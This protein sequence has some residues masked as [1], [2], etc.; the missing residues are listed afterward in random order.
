MRTIVGRDKHI[1]TPTN[2]KTDR[3]PADLS[4]TK[5][6]A[7]SAGIRCPNE[8]RIGQGGPYSAIGM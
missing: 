2:S 5:L 8:A 3:I 1:T 7:A 6:H 4:D